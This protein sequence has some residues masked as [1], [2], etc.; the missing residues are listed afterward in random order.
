M[1]R[2]APE[3]SDRSTC[4]HCR[5]R[6]RRGDSLRWPARLDR[7][8]SPLRLTERSEPIGHGINTHSRDRPWSKQG[9][10]RSSLSDS[11]I[12]WPHRRR[13]QAHGAWSLR[14]HPV[15][16]ARPAEARTYTDEPRRQD[17]TTA[18]SRATVDSCLA[19]SSFRAADAARL[20]LTDMSAPS[21][22]QQPKKPMELH[23]LASVMAARLL[24]SAVPGPVR[25]CPVNRDTES[26][27]C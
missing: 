6:G 21:R 27:A 4:R 20:R 19:C 13:Y 10:L 2:D 3:A 16:A 25:P 1:R 17:R 12:R 11:S 24:P 23:E 8:A 9:H 5:F 7:P 14:H 15:P 22:R 26:Y 18:A